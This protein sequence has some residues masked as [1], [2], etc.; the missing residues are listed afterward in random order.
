MP[1]R[2]V[3]P[4]PPYHRIRI[5]DLQPHWIP[6]GICILCRHRGDIPQAALSKVVV[7]VPRL[8]LI[9]EKIRCSACGYMGSGSYID[10]E[11]D[12]A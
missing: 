3:S 5:D 4:R 6:V 11:E 7:F 9:A 8:A 12:V 10:L 1:R 2:Q